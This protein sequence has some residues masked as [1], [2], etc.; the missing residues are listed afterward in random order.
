MHKKPSSKPIKATKKPLHRA[1]SAKR[2]AG[3]PY[4]A[5][6]IAEGPKL[7]KQTNLAQ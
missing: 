7:Q 4:E 6:P 1:K 5:G 2:D 3:D